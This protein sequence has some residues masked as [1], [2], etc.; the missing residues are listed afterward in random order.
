M[1]SRVALG[2]VEALG[3]RLAGAVGPSMVGVYA[4]GSAV[5]GGFRDGASDIDVLVVVEDRLSSDMRERVARVLQESHE[6]CPGRGIE[7]SVIPEGVAQSGGRRLDFEVHV[8]T[9]RRDREV[10]DGVR[11]SG[12]PDLILHMAVCRQSGIAVFGSAPAVVFAEIDRYS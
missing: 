7:A 8:N 6:S 2:F 12:D 5:L 11:H 1:A 10:V 3:E 9:D 4:H